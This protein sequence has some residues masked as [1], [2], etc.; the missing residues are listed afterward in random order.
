MGTVINTLTTVNA[1]INIAVT[2]LKDPV[3][4][5]GRYAVPTVD[6]EFFLKDHTSAF[7]LAQGSGGTGCN[8]GGGFTGQA[9]F[10]G[11]TGGQATGRMNADTG[12]FPGK[13]FMDKPGTGK[14]AGVT[15]DAP[16]H[17]G[18]CENFQGVGP[19]CNVQ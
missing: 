14:S 18:S 9:A 5:T 3:H 2:V 6:A 19:F 8:A 11:K 16:L 17:V 10:G 7:T 15:A 4:R 12:G 1:D 13:S